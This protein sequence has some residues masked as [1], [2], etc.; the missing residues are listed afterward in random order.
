MFS[1]VPRPSVKLSVSSFEYFLKEV[2]LHSPRLHLFNQKCSKNSTIANIINPF[3]I[4]NII[5][6]CNLIMKPDF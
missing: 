3:K 4:M 1:D 6:K 2:L 5:F